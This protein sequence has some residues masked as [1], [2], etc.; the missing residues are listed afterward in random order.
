MYL[1]ILESFLVHVKFQS[2]IAYGRLYFLTCFKQSVDMH[3]TIGLSFPACLTCLT[4]LSYFQKPQIAPKMF[5]CKCNT[6][7]FLFEK[8]VNH[9]GNQ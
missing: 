2:I 3:T 5:A 6:L 1:N 7:N 4:N 9:I 8:I